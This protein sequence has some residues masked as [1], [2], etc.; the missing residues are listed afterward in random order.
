MKH[1]LTILAALVLT[2]C[3]ANLSNELSEFLQTRSDSPLEG[4]VWEHQTDEQ[5][6]RYVTFHDGEISLF[7]GRE[8]RGTLHRYSDWFS[9]PYILKGGLIITTLTYNLY[10]RWETESVSVV[11]S[12]GSYTIDL[13]G[14][15]YHYYGPWND[16]LNEQ[17][18]AINCPIVPW[19][20][21]DGE[22]PKNYGTGN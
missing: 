21:D 3:T 11:K 15:L 1:L 20:V 16:V 12:Q 19:I 6:D 2:A 10:G 5:F 22:I 14:E 17:W 8:D 7:Y 13:D 18:I 4:T 9:A